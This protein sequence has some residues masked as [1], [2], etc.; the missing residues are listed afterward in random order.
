MSRQLT[1]RGLED[2]TV[3][4]LRIRAASHGQS[5]EAEV[6]SIL[7]GAVSTSPAEETLKDL[8]T[9]MPDLGADADFGRD[10]SPPRLVEL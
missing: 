1:V 7:R 2:D 3:R 8:L 6:R 5:M 4:S 10:D 9:A